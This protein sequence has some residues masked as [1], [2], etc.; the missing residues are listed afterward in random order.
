MGSTLDARWCFMGCVS[1]EF[2]RRYDV[3]GDM[4]YVWFFKV[5]IRGCKWWKH[6]SITVSTLFG[7]SLRGTFMANYVWWREWCRSECE[8][9]YFKIVKGLIFKVWHQVPVDKLFLCRKSKAHLISQLPGLLYIGKPKSTFGFIRDS[10]ATLP[11]AWLQLWTYGGSQWFKEP[12]L[13]QL[14]SV[15]KSVCVSTFVSNMRHNECNTAF[16]TAIWPNLTGSFLQPLFCDIAK[17]DVMAH[18]TEYIRIC[19]SSDEVRLSIIYI[20][21]LWQ[22]PTVWIL[23]RGMLLPFLSIPLVCKTWVIFAS[24]RV[25]Y[26]S[27]ERFQDTPLHRKMQP[28]GRL[29]E[30]HPKVIW[31]NSCMEMKRRPV[32]WNEKFRSK[33]NV[34]W[35]RGDSMKAKDQRHPKTGFMMSVPSTMFLT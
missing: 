18:Y 32:S 16:L 35:W 8:W 19:N 34:F 22:G 30:Q 26:G 11:R 14:V 9:R 7:W 13:D 31:A 2:E 17:L 23:Y 33:A 5:I 6:L 21:I 27:F 25:Y 24:C 10:Q 28:Q 15:R 12:G 1:W 3:T 20:Y 4:R 29:S